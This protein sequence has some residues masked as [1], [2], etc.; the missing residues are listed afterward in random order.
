MIKIH[1]HVFLRILAINIQ[2]DQLLAVSLGHDKN[3]YLHRKKWNVNVLF[4]ISIHSTN[5]LSTKYHCS[6]YFDDWVR[7]YLPSNI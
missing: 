5:K 4:T 2:H 1:W 3:K 7:F 6:I